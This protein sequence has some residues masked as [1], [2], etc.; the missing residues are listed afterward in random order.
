MSYEGG[1]RHSH[2]GNDKE[3]QGPLSI[4]HWLAIVRYFDPPF[5]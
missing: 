4:H 3:K 1:D 5:T 2:K